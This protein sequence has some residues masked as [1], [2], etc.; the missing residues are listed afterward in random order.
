M[1]AFLM[2]TG[3]SDS[4][5]FDREPRCG[6]FLFDKFALKSYIFFEARWNQDGG[7]GKE[8]K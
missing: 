2:V 4:T 8:M 1:S 7:G 6:Y 3:I 5:M